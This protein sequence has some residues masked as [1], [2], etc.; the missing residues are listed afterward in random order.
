M[1]RQRE[2]PHRGKLG[3]NHFR[4]ASCNNECLQ[5]LLCWGSL[6]SSMPAI[7]LS[8]NEKGVTN[9][10]QGRL[11]QGLMIQWDQIM[12]AMSKR[13][14]LAAAEMKLQIWSNLSHSS[15]SSNLSNV[16]KQLWGS[17]NR[18]LT[19]NPI[20]TKSFTSFTGFILGDGI[21]QLASKGPEPYDYARTAR[22]ASFGFTIHASGAH[23]FYKALDAMV[24]P[25]APKR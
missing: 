2:P 1:R 19:T 22:F 12:W 20:L 18:A 17:Y 16:A 4:I 9:E 8:D 6:A 10:C 14:W 3:L 23:F 5:C 21:A 25:N 7:W 11:F 15:M 24:F 13:Q